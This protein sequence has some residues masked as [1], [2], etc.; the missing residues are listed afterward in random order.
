MKLFIYAGI[1]F[2]MLLASCGE[3]SST[4]GPAKTQKEMLT[5][6]PWY[7]HEVS[8]GDSIRTDYKEM[9]KLTF[10]NGGMCEIT[11]IDGVH[12]STWL[13]NEKDSSFTMDGM[14]CPIVTLT[15]TKLEFIAP[16]DKSRPYEHYIWKFGHKP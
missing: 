3:D 9:A 6:H 4:N 7:F 12:V 5:A 13:M 8:K 2:A 1:L 10:K 15:E 16:I 14:E 11:G